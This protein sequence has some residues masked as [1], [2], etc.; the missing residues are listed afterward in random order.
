MALLSLKDTAGGGNTFVPYTPISTI[1]VPSTSSGVLLD[2]TPTEGNI[3]RVTRLSATSN[4]AEAGITVTIE[5]SNGQVDLTTNE[6][7]DEFQPTAHFFIG[8]MAF[9]NLSSGQRGLPFVDCKR[10]IV[11]KVSG[12]TAQS[13]TISY[14]EGR[15][16]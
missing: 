3:I 12:T 9:N 4:I 8:S 5:N 14:L 1:S 10:I 11:T 6:T 15:F 13:I 7:L 2:I 16:E